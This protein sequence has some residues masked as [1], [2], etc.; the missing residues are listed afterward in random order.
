[1]GDLQFASEAFQAARDVVLA[2][3]QQNGEALQF[4]SEALRADSGVVCVAVQQSAEAFRFASDALR[5]EWTDWYEV[6]LEEE[7]IAKQRRVAHPS[8]RGRYRRATRRR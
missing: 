7:F 2:A 5:D 4:A 6:D 1:M 3:V 8:A